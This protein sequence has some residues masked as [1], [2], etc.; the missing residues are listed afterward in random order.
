MSDTLFCYHHE[1]RSSQMECND[2]HNQSSVLQHSQP[3]TANI[4][5]EDLEYQPDDRLLSSSRTI[6][7]CRWQNMLQVDR[8]ILP[9]VLF[10]H[11]H[12]PH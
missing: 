11:H 5:R 2:P 6:N 10:G 3:K 1:L 9:S 8:I 12:Q 7:S 4:E